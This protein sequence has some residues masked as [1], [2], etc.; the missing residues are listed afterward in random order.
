[1]STSAESVLQAALRLSPDDRAALVEALIGSL[2]Q[3]DAAMDALWLKEAQ[4]RMATYRSGELGA[5]DAEEVFVQ[6]G[7]VRGRSMVA[8]IRGRARTRMSTDEIMALTRG[9]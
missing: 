3:P 9:S 8:R 6:L 2:D 5:V 1:M 7:A 4:D